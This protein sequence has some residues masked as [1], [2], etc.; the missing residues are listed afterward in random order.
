MSQASSATSTRSVAEGDQPFLF[1]DLEVAV[2][3]SSHQDP[4]VAVASSSHHDPEVAVASSSYQDP[5]VA[6]DDVELLPIVELLSSYS[7]AEAAVAA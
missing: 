6:D 5:E 4:E 1:Q 3:S 7:D 2:A